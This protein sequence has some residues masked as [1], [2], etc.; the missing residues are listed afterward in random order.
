MD[1]LKKDNNTNSSTALM[2]VDQL[3]TSMISS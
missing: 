3:N 1:I 2:V